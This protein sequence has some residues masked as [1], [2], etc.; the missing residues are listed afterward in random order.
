MLPVP[1][2]LR[3]GDAVVGH[4]DDLDE[5]AGDGVVVDDGG[6]GVDELDDELGHRVAGGGLRAED[7]SA[8]G[9]VGAVAREDAV[10]EDDD[11]EGEQELALVFVEALDLDVEER[12]G[13]DIDAEALAD[14][15][16]EGLL[17]TALGVAEGADEGGVGG[18]VLKAAE[19]REVADPAVADG[20]GDERGEARVGLEEPAALGD[21]V[22]LVGELGRPHLGVVGEDAFAEQLR[23]EGRDAVHRRGADDGEVGHADLLAALLVDDAHALEARDIAGVDGGDGAQEAGVDLEDDLDVAREEARHHRDAPALQGLREDGV[24]GVADAG[25][26][27]LPGV[28]PAEVLAVHEDAHKLRDGEGGVGVVELEEHALGEALE[29]Q[30]G[31][32]EAAEGVL[33]GAGDEEILLAESE[34]LALEGVVVGVEDLR[35]VLGE[36]LALYGLDIRAAVE[37]LE[38]ELVG[39]MG[40]PEAEGVADLAAETE[41]KAG[42]LRAGAFA[43]GE[44]TRRIGFAYTAD[45]DQAFVRDIIRFAARHRGRSLHK[46]ETTSF[47]GE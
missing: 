21:A 17:V 29:R 19:L 43:E 28:V 20:A 5:L 2:A 34:L 46:L 37:V 35:E 9:H 41:L 11:V 40:A 14:V 39:G 7:E 27:D 47:T 16:G 22:R 31:L 8:R 13:V 25:G 6:D 3:E 32:A 26:G 1:D 36:D 18:E 44:I 4:E 33:D 10:V 12:V 23:V 38:V 15:V 24:V 45:G 42:I 30:A